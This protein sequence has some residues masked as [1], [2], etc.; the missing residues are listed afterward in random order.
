MFG[1]V[2]R[3]AEEPTAKAIGEHTHRHEERLAALA[4]RMPCAPI[5]R[6]RP[7]RHEHVN[8]RMP[9][10]CSGPGVQH[11]QRTDA[12]TKPARIGAKRRERIERRLKQYVEQCA[13]MRTH[14]SSQLRR[15]RE[16]HVVVR[17]RQE[18]ALLARQPGSCGVVPA[19]R[20]RTVP[21]RVVAQM[22]ALTL[23]A[24]REVSPKRWRATACDRFDGTHVTGQYCRAVALQVAG[25]VPQE[26]VGEPEHGECSATG[27]P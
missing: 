8:M 9:F 23:G 1:R 19:S 24:A 17:G 15:E 4:R 2:R 10:E 20:A 7:C 25:S 27:R 21:A 3:S 22:L 26:H 16:H 11:R 14:G 18:Q 5:L 12:A 6:Q 13:L